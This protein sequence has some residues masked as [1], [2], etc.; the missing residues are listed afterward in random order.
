MKVKLFA[1]FLAVAIVPSVLFSVIQITRGELDVV[2]LLILAAILLVAIV[3]SLVF[4]RNTLL[5]FDE[6]AHYLQALSEGRL[7]G[8]LH[9]RIVCKTSTCA[10]SAIAVAQVLAKRDQVIAEQQSQLEGRMAEVNE[11]QRAL[12]T[13]QSEVERLNN[14]MVDRELRMIELKSELH[15]AQ[16]QLGLAGSAPTPPDVPEDTQ[17]LSPD[18]ERAAML[19]LLEDLQGE[20]K[21]LATAKAKDNAIFRSIGDGIVVAD[22]GGKVT[23]LN[24][25]ARVLL[26]LGDE[27]SD[28]DAW[29][30]LPP[31]FNPATNQPYAPEDIPLNK[32]VHGQV[33]EKCVM[34]IDDPGASRARFVEMNA[35]PIVVSGLRLGGVATVR[36][37]TKEQE[38]DR[39]K[40]EFVSLASHQLRTPLSAINWYAE[41][42]LAGDAGEINDEQR[43]YLNEVY[44]GNQRMV[45][46]IN[47]LLNVS[48]LELGTFAVD[49][50][51]TD[52]LALAESV[53]SE[54]APQIKERSITL[55]KHFDTTIPHLFADPKLV[56]MVVQNLASNAVKYTP[57]GGAV[58]VTI[59][60]T[61]DAVAIDVQDTGLGIPQADQYKIFSKL[62][63]ATNARE[64]DTD[65][66]GLGLYIVKSV[67]EHA[68][69]T[70]RFSSTEG[71]GTT[72]YVRLPKQGMQ[73]KEGPKALS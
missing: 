17:H 11:A 43:E 25:N 26:G 27:G 52:V 6:I 50:E 55:T 38:I 21:Q 3:A 48:R 42:L 14:V 4:A 54:L 58:T 12:S 24:H 5:P 70:I 41:M 65:G 68:G 64:S 44:Q 13:V 32:A 8:T 57:P 29:T 49:P 60:Q 22:A 33:V 35:T 47:S 18:Q 67:V 56:R 69:G 59:G 62:F 23:L 37:I 36:D 66:T 20:K 30:Q 53:L 7:D 1:Y 40:T 51:D 15:A 71:K 63:R 39:A 31:L 9:E 10:R 46:L 28:D 16:K 45:D 34:R 61:S 73:K 19:N 72:F 2:A